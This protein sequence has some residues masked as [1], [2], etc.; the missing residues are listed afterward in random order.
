MQNKIVSHWF[1]KDFVNLDPL[2]QKLHVFG[3]EL[4]GDVDITYGTGLS[5]F[6]GKRLAK[7][8]KLPEQGI[9]KLRVAISH[10]KQGLHWN[11]RF[12]DN[13]LVVSLFTPVNNITNGYWL[14]KTGPITMKLTVDIINGGWY[15]RCL[16]ISLFGIPMPLWL[17]PKSKAFKTI[18][19][20]K[21]KFNVAFTYPLLGN[22]VSY[23]GILVAQY[24]EH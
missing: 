6:I 13:N 21:Y 17:I 19:N 5:G 3:G 23:S 1:D 14:E 16:H 8:M 22:L 15:W 2:L 24:N 7:K 12:N 18:E 20:G 10:S 11:R 4:S 9:H